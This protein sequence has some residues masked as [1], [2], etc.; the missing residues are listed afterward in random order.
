MWKRFPLLPIFLALLGG[1]MSLRAQVPGSVASQAGNTAAPSGLAPGLYA[2]FSLARG[3]IVAELFFRRTPLTVASFVGL[4]EGKLGPTPGNPFFDGLIFHRVVPNYVVQGG[5]PLGTGFGGPGYEFADEFRSDLRHDAAGILSMANA[6]PDT[7]GSQFFFTLKPVRR[8]D[9]L[10]SVFGRVVQGLDLLPHIRQ[11]DAM[12]VRILRIG[13]EA[14]AF[15]T[16][17]PAFENLAARAPRFPYPFFDDRDRLLP[18]N[19]SSA[20]AFQTKLANLHRFTGLPLYVRLF[21]AREP[22]DANAKPGTLARRFAERFGVKDSGVVA[23]YYADR[24]EWALW[25]ADKLLPQFNSRG[26]T[27]HDA[28]QAVIAPARLRSEAAF[29]AGSSGSATPADESQKI[30]LFVDEIIQGLLDELQPATLP[31]ASAPGLPPR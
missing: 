12:S 25:I 19:P 26:L 15:Q 9:F 6:G 3:E 21:T 7:N 28:K 11:G 2:E 24:R 30:K 29:A 22:A 5:D 27:L 20:R 8:L 23:V 18:Q 1:S 13:P 4:A 31:A 16:E 10:H 14:E 17:K